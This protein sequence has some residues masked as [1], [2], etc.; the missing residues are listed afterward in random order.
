MTTTKLL[1]AAEAA[2]RLRC[3]PL[4]IKRLRL[5]GLLAYIPGRPVLIPETAI[6]AYI[7]EATVK[8]ASLAKARESRA[9]RGRKEETE[10]EVRARARRFFEMEA[11][12]KRLKQQRAAELLAKGKIPKPRGG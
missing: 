11:V 10:A 5:A 1:T 7:A 6:E 3:K 8:A 9:G 12:T 4:R 2:E